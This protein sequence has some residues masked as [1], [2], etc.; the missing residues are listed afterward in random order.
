MLPKRPAPTATSM[1]AMKTAIAL[2][3]VGG[4]RAS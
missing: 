1:M 4:G 3:V 2:L